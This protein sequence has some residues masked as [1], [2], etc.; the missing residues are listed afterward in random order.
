MCSSLDKIGIRVF[1]GA[2]G[3]RAGVPA[4]FATDAPVWWVGGRLVL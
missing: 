4:G 2:N 3:S 1:R